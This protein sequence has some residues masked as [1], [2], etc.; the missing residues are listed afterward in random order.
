MTMMSGWQVP[1]EQ[2]AMD[3]SMASAPASRAA[4]LVL[5]PMPA[6]SWVWKWMKVPSGSMSRAWEMVS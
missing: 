6:V 4:M 5:T 2:G 3:R 1:P